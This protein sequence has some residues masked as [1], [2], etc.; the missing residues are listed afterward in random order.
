[1]SSGKTNIEGN[2]LK[3]EGGG[4]WGG[5]RLGYFGDLRDLGEKE[6]HYVKKNV[7]SSLDLI[8]RCL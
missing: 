7:F 8:I 5:W 3:R 1:M 6:G 2:W 4:G